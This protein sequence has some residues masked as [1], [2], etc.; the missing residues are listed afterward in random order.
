[1]WDSLGNFA[2][3]VA[4]NPYE[5]VPQRCTTTRPVSLPAYW[6]GSSWVSGE[7]AQ[8]TLQPVTR[9]Q[10]RTAL[11][12]EYERRMVVIAAGYPPSERESWPVQTGEA[13]AL[14]SDSTAPTPWIDAAAA[15]RSLDRL[16]LAQ[17]IV[18][19]DSQYRVY[20]GTLSGVRQ[21]IEDAIDDAS[22]D[23]AALQLVDVAA[24]WPE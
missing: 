2:G 14:L 13:Y 12:A 8:P 20:S 7:A 6:N 24:G 3:E 18:A 23:V 22:E 19:K 17:R 11:A 1:M 21:R 5:A 9:D 4:V 15:A 16:E 10:L